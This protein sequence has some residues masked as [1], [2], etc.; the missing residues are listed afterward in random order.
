M[1]WGEWI[2]SDYN[3][4]GFMFDGGNIELCYKENYDP[5]ITSYYYNYLI[6]EK[7]D[8]IIKDNIY[9]SK[10]T[11]ENWYDNNPCYWGEL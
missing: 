9:Q 5:F 11:S 3:I 4:Y 6:V 10:V 7:N 8:K 1:S 2:K